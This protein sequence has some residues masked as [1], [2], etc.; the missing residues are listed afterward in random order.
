MNKFKPDRRY[1]YKALS[2]PQS[3]QRTRV[4][5]LRSS[6]RRRATA[7]VEAQLERIKSAAASGQN[8][9]PD[10]AGAVKSD[11]TLGEISDVLREVFGEY[12]PNSPV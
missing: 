5:Q 6:K 12:R 1:S 2:L 8:L 7:S 11:C 10:I 9:M 4:A 3:I